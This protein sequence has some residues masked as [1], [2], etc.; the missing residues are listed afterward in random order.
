VI[1][2]DDLNAKQLRPHLNPNLKYH[3]M[4]A[5]K[6]GDMVSVGSYGPIGF[7]VCDSV[8]GNCPR[9]PG[10]E[11]FD[12]H[13]AFSD[14]VLFIYEAATVPA[15]GGSGRGSGGSFVYSVR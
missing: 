6:S 13:K 4:R 14:F 3:F 2:I 15:S 9:A 10:Q 7:Y 12:G 5:E 11:P 8:D 1:C